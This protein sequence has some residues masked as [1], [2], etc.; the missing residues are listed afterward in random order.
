M[1]YIITGEYGARIDKINKDILSVRKEGDTVERI[2]SSKFDEMPISETTKQGSMFGNKS[3][4]VF[5]DLLSLKDRE[6]KLLDHAKDMV[7]SNNVF[8]LHETKIL[9]LILNK[10]EKA[11]GEIIE[12]KKEKL[13]GKRKVYQDE[14]FNLFLLTEALGEKNKKKLW[15]LFREAVEKGSPIEEI[16]GLLNW[17][18]KN[19]I[20]VKTED[21]NPDMHP[22]AYR[23]TSQF[24]KNFEMQDLQKLSGDLV[25]IFHERET[26]IPLEMKIEGFILDL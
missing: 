6:E 5:T 1:L 12:I 18:V 16:H 25:R 15:I 2:E 17:Q 8:I 7:E 3:F 4:F 24:A 19:M 9:K 13:E 14:P 11:G 10:L 20:M 26:G 23:K 21:G 22:F